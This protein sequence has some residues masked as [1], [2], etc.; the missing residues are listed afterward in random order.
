MEKSTENCHYRELVGEPLR[1]ELY[2]TMPLEHVTELTELRKRMSPIAVKIIG[3]VGKKIT[4][5]K[6]CSPAKWLIAS[7][8]SR[9]GMF[10]HSLQI[11]FQFFL[12]K[13][14][15]LRNSNPAKRRVTNG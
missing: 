13:N 3:L 6:P 2:F 14:S 9:I 1:L 11:M 15:P 4:N 10:C 7:L 5:G 8:Y 12:V